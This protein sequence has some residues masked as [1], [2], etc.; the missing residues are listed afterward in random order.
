[1]RGAFIG[2]LSRIG[3]VTATLEAPAAE[4]PDGDV[5]TPPPAPRPVPAALRPWRDPNP[6]LGWAI[7]VFV[8]AVAAFTRFWAIGF[9]T[10]KTFDEVYYATEA[11]ELLRFGYEDNRAYMFIVHPPLGKWLIALSSSI[12]G[13]TEIGWRVAPAVFGTLAVLVLTRTVRRMMRSNVFGGVAGLLFALDGLSVVLS[14][15]A[16]LDI[17]LQFFVVAG[18][19]ALVVDRDRMRGRLAALIA[20]GADLASGVPTLGPRPWRLV[21]GVMFGSACAVKWTALS[22][23][24]L[25]ALLS[26]LW[27]RA[28]LRSAGVTRPTRA[29]LRRS[30]APATGSL[31][32]APLA[33]Y[34]LTYLGWFLGEN[35][36][37]R[38]WTDSHP[39]STR[40]DLLGL[41]VGFNWGWV[42][43]PIR[44]LGS[45]TLDAYRF[46][47]GLD[48]GHPYRSSPWSWLVLGRPVDFYYDGTSAA[49]G[50]STC[51]REILLIGTPLLWWA[52]VPMLLWLAWHWITTR[53]WRAAAVWVAFIAGWV[54][55]FQDLKRT[56]FLFY[57]APLVPFLIIGVTLGLGVMLGAPARL[58]GD[59]GRDARAGRRRQWGLAGVV[60]FL[61]LVIADF[62]WMW[63]LFTGGLRTYDQWHAHM[64]LP[65]WV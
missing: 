19:A 34:L 25:F 16:L 48:S 26:V 23:F 54:V 12:W 31:V 27:D 36:W 3:T 35:S 39:A 57:M 60:I 6:R 30:A 56:M 1:L 53:D 21:A 51:S 41:R 64:W 20:D 44:S 10:G 9:P 47:E 14:R 22:F 2:R 59:Q 11:Q 7:A 8:T 40:L 13:N 18:F 5:V 50:S 42:P 62:A 45:Y 43:S 33:A 17:F 4:T 65:S 46:H 38:H 29:M 32:A 37:N 49:C 24:V 63:P 28:A 15:T 61:S 52:F 58:T 55:W